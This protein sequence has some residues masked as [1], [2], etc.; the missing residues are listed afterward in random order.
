MLRSYFVDL[1]QAVR[2]EVVS[3][4]GRPAG[5]ATDRKEAKRRAGLGHSG[6]T[7]R[8]PHLAAAAPA[9]PAPRG[10]REPGPWRHLGNWESSARS[11]GEG[12]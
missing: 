8:R 12:T 6:L 4:R 3:L 9:R 11:H 10:S 2:A 7:W 5:V 1:K